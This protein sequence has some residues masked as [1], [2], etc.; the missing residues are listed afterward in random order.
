MLSVGTAGMGVGSGGLNARRLEGNQ[1][2]GVDDERIQEAM[3]TAT[4]DQAARVRSVRRDLA[5]NLP[6][7]IE[8]PDGEE[9]P[10][11]VH[12]ALRLRNP[13]QV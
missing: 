8:L 2:N 6:P 13:D 7:R 5:L 9:R 10:Y 4:R 11:D 12:T 3:A 1:G